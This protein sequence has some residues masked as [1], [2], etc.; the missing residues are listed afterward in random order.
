MFISSPP[1]ASARIKAARLLHYLATLFVTCGLC[2][3]YMCACVC[4]YGDCIVYNL[5]LIMVFKHLTE[6]QQYKH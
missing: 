2:G 4:D 3:W 6:Q 5:I 1:L